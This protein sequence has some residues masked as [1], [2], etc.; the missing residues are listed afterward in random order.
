M[1]DM[2]GPC[3]FISVE[4]LHDFQVSVKA[5][6]E[7]VWVP[8]YQQTEAAGLVTDI[9]FDSLYD[10]RYMEIKITS[11]KPEYLTICELEVYGKQTC[12]LFVGFF[13]EARKISHQYKLSNF[14]NFER[15]ST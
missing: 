2:I 12:C 6:A 11:S 8:V 5:A 7:D 1:H 3:D 9:T 13:F 14:G 15:V 4:R 10:A